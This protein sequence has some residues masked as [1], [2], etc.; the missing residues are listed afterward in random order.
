MESVSAG[1]PSARISS[2]ANGGRYREG[3][4]VS[5]SFSCYEGTA[6]PGLMSCTDSNGQHAPRGHLNTV[7]TG[8]HTYTV[9]AASKDG[10]KAIATIGYTI[11]LPP[12][13]TVAIK[14]ARAVARGQK[15]G[16]TLA[17]SPRWRRRNCRGTL[18]LTARVKER[19]HRHRTTITATRTTILAR[20][21]YIVHRGTKRLIVIRLNNAA[22]RLIDHAPHH[23]LRIRAIATLRFGRTSADVIT[24]QL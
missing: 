23:R 9:T 24:L 2:P 5:T 20:A 19:I 21:G 14:T 12:P 1:A 16:I 7:R 17:C 10:Q 6:G 22:S 18:T 11:V 4:L 8:R 15:I 13:A 3:K